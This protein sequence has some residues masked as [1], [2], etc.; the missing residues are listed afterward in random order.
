MS[1][2]PQAAEQAIKE[3]GVIRDQITGNNFTERVTAHY[4]KHI[5]GDIDEYIDD[6]K[7]FQLPVAEEA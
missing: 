1:I 4:V 7:V 3:L 6:L 5:L 2:S